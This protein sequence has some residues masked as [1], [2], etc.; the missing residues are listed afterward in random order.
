[1]PDDEKAGLA[2]IKRMQGHW[3]RVDPFCPARRR[4]R[5]QD[6]LGDRL[7]AHIYNIPHGFRSTARKLPAAQLAW[8]RTLAFYDRHLNTPRP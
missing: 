7:D 8:Q 6:A 5:L 2:R 3:S 1:M 4:Q